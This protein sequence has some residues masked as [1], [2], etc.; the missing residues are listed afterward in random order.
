MKTQAR[1]LGAAVLLGALVVGGAALQKPLKING[2]EYNNEKLLNLFISYSPRYRQVTVRW[3]RND[4]TQFTQV[5][6][7]SPWATT[8]YVREMDKILLAGNQE[9]AGDLHCLITEV[10]AAGTTGAQLDISSRDDVGSVRCYY[11][12]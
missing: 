4:V 8:I 12:R 3:S 11:N 1:L 10:T 6:M 7:R 9:S 2:A 5:V